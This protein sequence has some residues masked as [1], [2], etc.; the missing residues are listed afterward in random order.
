MTRV[1]KS[2]KNH[3]IDSF[4]INSENLKSFLSSYEI[5]ISELEYVSFTISKLY[6]QKVDAI[7]ESCGNDWTRLDSSPSPLI[8]FVQC[9]DDLLCE[10]HLDISSRC[11]F[12]LN[13]FSKTLESWMIW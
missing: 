7:L 9:I 1:P 6:N 2:I 11:R 10:D 3:Y 13:S 4:L 5:S 12:I 8:L